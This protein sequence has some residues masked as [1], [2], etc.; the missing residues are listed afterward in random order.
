M[1]SKKAT[2][3]TQGA[4][5]SNCSVTNMPAT[6]NEHT[7]AAVEALAGAAKANAEAIS[8]IARA[9][10]GGDARIDSAFRF[11]A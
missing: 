8:A 6:A 1:T 3:T 2:K 9:L 5:V 4:T 11:G 10:Q 7:R